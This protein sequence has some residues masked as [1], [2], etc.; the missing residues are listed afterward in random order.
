MT[1]Y[2]QVTQFETRKLEA[3]AWSQLARELAAAAP[4]R[5]PRARRRLRALLTRR[6]AQACV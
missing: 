3:E 1:M 5:R 4:A 6:P 2:P